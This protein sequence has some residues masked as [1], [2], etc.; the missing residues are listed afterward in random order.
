MP[1][2]SEKDHEEIARWIREN[3]K[4]AKE[5][6]EDAISG[7]VVGTALGGIVG[8]MVGVATGAIGWALKKLWNS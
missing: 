4:D 6:R 1:E 3:P 7:G 8:G 5:L 2:L